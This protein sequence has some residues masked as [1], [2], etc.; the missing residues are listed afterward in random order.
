M[1]FEFNEEQLNNLMVFL[2]RVEMKG[3]QELTAMN[4]ILDVLQ[5]SAK[6]DDK[7]NNIKLT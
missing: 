1:L 4:Q 7:D 6:K 5:N 2:N 3:F